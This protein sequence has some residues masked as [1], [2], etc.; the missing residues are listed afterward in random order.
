MIVRSTVDT[1]R[2]PVVW[3][4]SIDPLRYDRSTHSLAGLKTVP[5][6]AFI[7]CIGKDKRPWLESP[8]FIGIDCLYEGKIVWFLIDTDAVRDPEKRPFGYDII[9][10]DD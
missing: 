7:T 10:V 8:S 6:G 3:D 4:G 1:E 5:T 9:R 2:G